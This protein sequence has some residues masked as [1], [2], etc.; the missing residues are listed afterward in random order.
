MRLRTGC[1]LEERTST[2]T[3]CT[4][5]Y[6]HPVCTIL[7]EASKIRA[8]C[9]E[10]RQKLTGEDISDTQTVTCLAGLTYTSVPL[11]FYERVIGLLQTGQVFLGTPSAKRHLRT[12]T[13]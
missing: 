2:A 10:V 9:L 7:A 1:D 12:L 11:K 4:Q 6:T 3:K 5:Y 13:M 8:E